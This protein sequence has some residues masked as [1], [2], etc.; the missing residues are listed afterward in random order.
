MSK[1]KK[2]EANFYTFLKIYR[3]YDEV[4]LNYYNILIW[5]KSLYSNPLS[6]GKLGFDEG[7]LKAYAPGTQIYRGP[8]PKI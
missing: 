5:I 2:V 3:I 6:E 7:A 1:I 4:E 8:R